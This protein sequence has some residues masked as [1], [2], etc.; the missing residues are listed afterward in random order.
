MS[1]TFS[2][3]GHGPGTLLIAGH[4]F[5]VLLHLLH[6]FDGWA[7]L[8]DVWAS[9]GAR[10]FDISRSLD[11]LRW[12]DTLWARDEESAARSFSADSCARHVSRTVLSSGNGRRARSFFLVSPS[13]IPDVI[14]VM[15]SLS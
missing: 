8:S 1:H 3:A 12:R 7:A 10:T 2:L 6:R 14:S 4:H 11:M 9:F 5:P 13:R 15:R